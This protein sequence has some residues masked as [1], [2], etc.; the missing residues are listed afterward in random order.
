VTL[1]RVTNALLT[2]LP[3]ECKPLTKSKIS[4]I[5]KRQ[6]SDEN[7]NNFRTKLSANDWTPVYTAEGAENKF[8][9][10]NNFIIKFHNEC[11]PLVTTKIK[12][13]NIYKPW[14]T[15]SILNS[16]RKKNNMYKN[17]IKSHS[18][19]LKNKY[20]KYKNKLVTIIR[21]AEKSYYANKLAEVKDNLSK[22]WK[23]MNEMCGRN[24]VQKQ[25]TKIRVNDETIDDPKQ[26]ANKFK[27][28]FTNIGPSLAKV[29]LLALN[30]HLISGSE[31]SLTRC[32][33]C[34]QMNLKFRMF[35]FILFYFNI[36]LQSFT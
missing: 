20:V 2:Y 23:V 13:R 30:N 18:P 3:Y 25:I 16:V 35:Y 4:C 8:N 21:E 9:V 28:Y 6:Y 22:T 29:I 15:S 14:L 5:H 1:W 7:M 26:I 11:F 33:W 19:I 12:T 17:Y 36:S 24:S 10:F 32:S 34:P 31:V 27:E